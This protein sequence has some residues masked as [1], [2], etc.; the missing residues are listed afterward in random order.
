[1]VG[2]TGGTHR[3]ECVD[4]GAN[5]TAICCGSMTVQRA[6]FTAEL[7]EKEKKKRRKE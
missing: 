3:V 2:P 7:K 1:M 4:S 6:V 5:K